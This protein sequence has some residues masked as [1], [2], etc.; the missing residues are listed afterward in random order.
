MV[1]TTVFL[2]LLSTE[3]MRSI[4]GVVH[5]FTTREGGVS[6]G[7]HST[8]NLAKR[9]D[10][11]EMTLRE[12]WGRVTRQLDSRFSAD[13]VALVSQ[14]H[15][16]RVVVATGP[17]GPLATLGQA[18][19][20]ITDQTGLVLAV[21]VADCV[22][23]LLASPGGI[24]AV[25]S[26]WRGAA[27]DIIGVAVRA[28]CELTGDPAESVVASVGPHISGA[29]YEV[30]PEVVEGLASSGVPQSVFV[31]PG[32]RGRPHVDLGA[33]VGAQLSRAGVAHVEHVGACTLTQ[34]RFY[35]YRRDG[36]AAGRLAGVIAR[37]P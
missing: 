22:P 32:K 29:A 31:R 36:P 17:S 23:I 18:D 5:G 24:G 10:E 19:A 16:A 35:S 26:G 33:V 14:V 34:T 12:N 8:L 25:H 2:P 6:Q 9:P 15:G 3:H 27:L 13:D 37:V 21:R 7:T 30:G 20:V 4:P 11:A 28:L 1:S